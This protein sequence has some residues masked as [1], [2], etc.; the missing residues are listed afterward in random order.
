MT[1]HARRSPSLLGSLPW[2]VVGALLVATPVLAQERD[3]TRGMDRVE[4]ERADEV[5]ELRVQVQ[6]RAGRL[7]RTLEPGESLQSGDLVQFLVSVDRPAWVYVVQRFSDG[8]ASVLYPE[9]ADV[10]LQPGLE[11]RIPE[12]GSWFR[13]DEIPGEEH[14]FF[15]ASTRPLAEADREVYEAV[16]AVRVEGVQVAALGGAEEDGD[17]ATARPHR[18]APAPPSP[19]ADA[20]A[21]PSAAPSSPSPQS[22]ATTEPLPAIPPPSTF[23]LGTRGLVKTTEEGSAQVVSDGEGVAIYHF[24]FRHEPREREVAE[25]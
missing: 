20:P 5:V 9:H 8:S 1:K 7:L 14:V 15:V 4:P 13:L 21:K 3:Q 19:P 25:P 12:A 18:P 23:T 6:A 10:R 17:T 22:Q 16:E 11:T 24:W 2:L